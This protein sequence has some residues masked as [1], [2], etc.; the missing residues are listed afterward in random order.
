MLLDKIGMYFDCNA[1]I[2]KDMNKQRKAF[3]EKHDIKIENFSNS[4]INADLT[5]KFLDQA[6]INK[7]FS[8]ESSK[9]IATYFSEEFGEVR[10]K[11]IE[12]LKQEIASQLDVSKVVETPQIN[13]ADIVSKLKKNISP[14]II[15]EQKNISDE[16][17]PYLYF[18]EFE[19]IGTGYHEMVK[20]IFP[21]EIYNDELAEANH[22]LVTIALKTLIKKNYIEF[23]KK[24]LERIALE[25]INDY[26]ETVDEDLKN[27]NA[28]LESL[29][30]KIKSVYDKRIE[31]LKI[32][33]SLYA[34]EQK[35]T[36]LDIKGIEKLGFEGNKF[37][38]IKYLNMEHPVE[39]A[40]RIIVE[41]IN[42][43]IITKKDTKT[44]EEIF[45]LFAFGQ[46]DSY[47]FFNAGH[48][49]ET[50]MSRVINVEELKNNTKNI[51][52]HYISSKNEYI[53]LDSSS[54]GMQ[55]NSI[56]EY[57]LNQSSDIPLLIDQPEDNVD[58]EA[59]YNNLTKWIKTNKKARQIILVSHD[60][61]IVINGD[62]E[63]LIVADYIN[64][65][66]TYSC[67][68]LEYSNNLDLAA[69][70]LDGG[71]NAVRRRVQKYGE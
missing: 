3:L 42:G 35:L 41:A 16:Y 25:K 13:V 61:N 52:I 34:I 57:V 29:K 54:P 20:N 51:I 23:R 71:V 27:K 4:D 47:D 9:T 31:K 8:D 63:N 64:G 60:A 44:T 28:L 24:A 40:K 43:S 67:G 49:I 14:S 55:T 30:T 53:A 65:V 12:R 56:M 69:K 6:Y 32:I 19:L 50:L 18:E 45:K 11:P 5:V 36:E 62:A 2:K 17:L 38:F 26:N 68:G 15:V 21:E 33:N 59:R 48:T 70:L 58:N 1:G 22:E 7:L 10:I 46:N 39:C 37:F 66:F